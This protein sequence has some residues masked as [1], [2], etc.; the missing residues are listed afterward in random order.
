MSD[1]IL[2]KLGDT[3]LH[4]EVERDNYGSQE[5][6]NL[7]RTLN[8]AEQSFDTVKQIIT[9]LAGE[10]VGAIKSMDTHLTPDEFSIEFSIK[11]G[12]E[13]QVILTKI[14]AEAQI[15]VKMTHK[16]KPVSP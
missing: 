10:L 1:T 11:F 15:T 16:H 5:T 9:N 6:S 2:V 4:V 12:A 8:A 3:Y 13:G 7:D 14:G